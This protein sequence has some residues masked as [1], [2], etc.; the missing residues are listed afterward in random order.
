[1]SGNLS[2]TERLSLLS[3]FVTA[4]EF[5]LHSIQQNHGKSIKLLPEYLG[6]IT[7]H[8]ECSRGRNGDKDS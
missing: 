7:D 4:D 2:E 6:P 3:L 5:Q 8:V 1:M